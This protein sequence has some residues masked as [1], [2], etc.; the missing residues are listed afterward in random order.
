MTKTKTMRVAATTRLI[1]LSHFTPPC[2]PVKAEITKA[3]PSTAMI[4]SCTPVLWSRPAVRSSPMAIC[5]APRPRLVAVPK[6]VAKTASRSRTLPKTPFARR[7]PMRGTNTALNRLPLP[8]RKL[9]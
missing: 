6:T 2:R 4:T 5:R 1:E 8:C 9:A 7:A 3:A